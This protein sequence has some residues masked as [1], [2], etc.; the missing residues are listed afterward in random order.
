MP[1]LDFLDSN[2]LVYAH[3]DT[4]LRKKK[5]AQDLLRR[6]VLGEAVVSTQSL[7]EFATTLLHKFSPPFRP[8]EV[9]EMLDALSP[10]KLILPDQGIVRRAVEAR[11]TYGLHFY[12]GMI[13]AAAERG[14]CE[15]IWSEDL[16]AGQK[17]F[18]IEVRNPFLE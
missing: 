6:A 18:G 15:R 10:V 11:E 17:Y 9:V 14:E 16:N 3:D 5:I 12:D 2:I 8:D 7:T 13:V 1:A 4:D